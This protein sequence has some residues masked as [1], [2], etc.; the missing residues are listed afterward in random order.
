MMK[1][2]SFALILFLISMLTLCCTEDL[3]KAEKMEML[4]KKFSDYL[5]EKNVFADCKDGYKYLL[6]AILLA[7]ADTQ[8]SGEFRALVTEASQIFKK[9]SIFNPEGV[10]L[11]HKAY[12]LK[13]G[14]EGFKMPPNIVNGED[15]ED[16]SRK[17]VQGAIKAY[18]EGKPEKTV[19]LLIEMALLVVTPIE[20]VL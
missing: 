3:T 2:L 9:T 18:Q 12:A 20:K 16:Y 19:K 14:G 10:T 8:L 11:L 6:E 13:H 4:L 7:A 15:A 1:N 5:I 17:S